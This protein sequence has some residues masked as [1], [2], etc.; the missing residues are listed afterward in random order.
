VLAKLGRVCLAFAC[1]SAF[2]LAGCSKAENSSP[3]VTIKYT[4]T[5]QPVKVGTTTIILALMDA[6]AHPVSGAHVVME[7]DMSHAG[8]APVFGD[9]IETSPGQYQAHLTLNMAGDWAL[10]AHVTLVNG[11]KLEQQIDLKAVQAN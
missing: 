2:F 9:A 6:S 8:M 1:A 11:R 10:L 5:P 3:A 4:I 7:G